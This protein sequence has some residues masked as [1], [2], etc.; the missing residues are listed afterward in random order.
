MALSSAPAKLTTDD[1][2]AAIA[3]LQPTEAD[4]L[5][6]RL[7]YLQAQRKA[8]HMPEYEAALLD[9]IYQAKRPGFR[10][11][12]DELSSKF[13]TSTLTPEEHEEMLRL[14]DEAEAFDVQRLE[15]LG[16]LAKIRK[17]TVPALMRKLGLKAPQVV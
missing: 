1:I 4:Q 14:T 11:R 5:T 6:L 10:E 8:P 7:L 13:R 2:F 9:R 3:Q 16:E 12:F 17:M 15:A